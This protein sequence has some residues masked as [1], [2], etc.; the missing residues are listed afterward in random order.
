MFTLALATVLINPLHHSQPKNLKIGDM[1]EVTG[2]TCLIGKES[3]V[4][5]ETDGRLTMVSSKLIEFESPT[6]GKITCS[7]PYEIKKL[8]K[9]HVPDS[10]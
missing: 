8:G 5:Y 6:L 7:A 9:N 4:L 3:S 2:N 10:V 1:I